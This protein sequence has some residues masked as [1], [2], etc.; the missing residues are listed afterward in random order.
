[1]LFIHALVGVVVAIL[2][3]EF[4]VF[5]KKIIIDYL[6]KKKSLGNFYRDKNQ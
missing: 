2:D 1:M 3:P 5:Y 4:G 6:L